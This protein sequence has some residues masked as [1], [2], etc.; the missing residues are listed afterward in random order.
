MTWE[1]AE[2]ET[3]RKKSEFVVSLIPEIVTTPAA[4]NDNF[5]VIDIVGVAPDPGHETILTPAISVTSSVTDVRR[6]IVSPEVA[7]ASAAAKV[8]CVALATEVAST[9]NLQGP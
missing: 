2:P 3:T 6:K 7:T 5:P 4:E 1:A 9:M 8:E